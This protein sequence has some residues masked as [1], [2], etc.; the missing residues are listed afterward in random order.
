MARTQS[1]DNFGM[2]H[3]E[4][5]PIVTDLLSCK[6]KPR[7][8]LP[9]DCIVLIALFAYLNN[10][11]GRVVVNQAQLA[12]DLGCTRPMVTTSLGRLRKANLLASGH[13][14]RTGERYYLFNPQ[15][16][17]VGTPNKRKWLFKEYGELRDQR[18]DDE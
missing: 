1:K 9:K 17:S 13:D 16:F 12:E 10:R 6:E 15:V 8:L 7:L 14:R 11:S 18:E 3:I 2:F 4:A 5:I